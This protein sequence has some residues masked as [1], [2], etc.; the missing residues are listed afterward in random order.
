MLQGILD[1][2]SK[3][4]VK[5]LTYRPHLGTIDESMSRA[6]T[7]ESTRP[8]LLRHL[9]DQTRPWGLELEDSDF[10]VILYS[11]RPDDRIG[12]KATYIVT[13]KRTKDDPHA[14]VLGFTNKLPSIV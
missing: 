9:N 2:K 13:I 11:D 3:E 1:E 14:T 8:A 4:E 6:V 5:T 10:D 7:L 12:W